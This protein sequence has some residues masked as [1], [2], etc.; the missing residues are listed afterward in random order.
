M[1]KIRGKRKQKETGRQRE[2][3]SER[4]RDMEKKGKL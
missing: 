3:T 2:M 1:V 4:R